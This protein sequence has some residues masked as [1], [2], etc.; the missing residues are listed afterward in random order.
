MLVKAAAYSYNIEQGRK[1]TH[2]TFTR[3]YQLTALEEKRIQAQKDLEAMPPEK[4]RRQREKIKR[5]ERQIDQAR[6]KMDG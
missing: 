1:L 4:R 6:L 2:E 3:L 5:I